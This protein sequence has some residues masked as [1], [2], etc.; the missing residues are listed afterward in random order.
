MKLGSPQGISAYA[1]TDGAS[2]PTQ[3]S[4][5]T[6]IRPGPG[7][8]G[9]PVA[10]V[11]ERRAPASE[12]GPVGG[13][14]GDRPGGIDGPAASP[15]RLRGAA[16]SGARGGRFRGRRQTSGR[17][18]FKLHL[19]RNKAGNNAYVWRPACPTC[20]RGSAAK[21][22]GRIGGGTLWGLLRASGSVADDAAAHRSPLPTPVPLGQLGRSNQK[23]TRAAL[24]RR[25]GSALPKRATRRGPSDNYASSE[26]MGGTGLLRSR[27]RPFKHATRP[28]AFLATGHVF[29][30]E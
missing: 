29:D 3:A 14:R 27:Y 7:P 24:A 18:T 5:E 23:R 8:N 9:R 10:L 13:M 6:K 25:R 28:R 2:Q 22:A 30:Y 4:L 19:G 12:R 16:I 26:G 17:P 21:R 1:A 11:V 15:A 20:F